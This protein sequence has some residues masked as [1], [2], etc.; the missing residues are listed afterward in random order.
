MQRW[1]KYILVSDVLSLYLAL[2][3][4]LIVRGALHPNAV[5]DDSVW[6]A[7][8]LFIFLPS[9]LF[10]VLA[11][12]VAGLYEAKIIYDRTKTI[13]LLFY[14]QFASAIF[15]V[16]SFYVLRTEL[17]PKLTLF[18]FVIISIL[19]LSITRGLVYRS[20]S[21]LK[22]PTSYFLTDREDLLK[23]LNHSWA[24]YILETIRSSQLEDFKINKKFLTTLGCF[25]ILHTLFEGYPN[26]N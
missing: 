10:S 15:S 26:A 19:I 6:I 4:A 17:T 25:V 2:V 8:H 5:Q 18:F 1:K 3:L 7:A 16:L 11:L 20:I 12:Y 22:K 13:A 21:K 9:V 23:N 14:A 24:P